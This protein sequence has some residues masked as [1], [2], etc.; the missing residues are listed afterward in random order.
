MAWEVFTRELVKDSRALV[1]VLSKL[2][3]FIPDPVLDRLIVDRHRKV[4]GLLREVVEARP[5]AE[6]PK[7]GASGSA[8]VSKTL[9][10]ESSEDCLTQL[11]RI[12]CGLGCSSPDQVLMIVVS[13]AFHPQFV[14]DTRC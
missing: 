10:V 9:S 6:S 12:H 11:R 5:S 14:E 8:T 3:L 2:L 4:V 7:D 1:S 13:I